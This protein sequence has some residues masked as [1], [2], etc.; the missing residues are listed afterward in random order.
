MDGDVVRVA[1]GTVGTEGEDYGGLEVAE[2]TLDARGFAAVEAQITIWEPPELGLFGPEDATGVSQFFFA[3]FGEGVSAL[4]A[5]I[6]ALAT[7]A[8]G[9]ALDMAAPARTGGEGDRPAKA[10]GLVV[11]VGNDGEERWHEEDCGLL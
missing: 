2:K 5:A 11:G 8:V 7:F 10:I 1:V 4:G 9:G 6:V 3:R